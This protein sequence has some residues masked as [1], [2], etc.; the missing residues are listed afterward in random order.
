[1]AKKENVPIKYTSRDFASIRSDL[2][3]YAKKYYPKT[4]KDFNE[5]SFGALMLDTVAYTGDILSFYLD[6]QANESFLD[7]AVEVN[8]VIRL[9]KQT[10]YNFEHFSTSFGKVSLYVL[11]PANA[12]GIGVNSDYVPILK[13]GTSFSSQ[14]GGNFILTNDVD[15]SGQDTEVIAAKFDDNTSATTYYAIKSEGA[16]ISGDMTMDF[17][18][19]GDYQPY[20]SAELAGGNT[21]SEIVSVIDSLGN[22]YYEVDYL[23]QDTIYI[24]VSNTGA[25][26]D[27][28]PS[29]M[30]PLSVPRRFVVVKE[31]GKTFLQ[32][33]YGAEVELSSETESI[34]DPSEVVLKL[35]GKDHIVDETFDPANLLG[36]DKLGVSPANTTLQVVYRVNTSMNSNAATDSV[37]SVNGPRVEFPSALEG[38]QL[39]SST[40]N[41]VV[42]SLE[43]KNEEPILG[44]IT[45]P[46]IKEIKHRIKNTF[47]T[48]NRAVTLEDYQ[49]LVYRMPG[50]Y[51]AI[52]K[53]HIIPD[54]NSFKRNLNFYILSEDVS[55]K[56]IQSNTP[57]K[58]NLKTWINRYK[59]I[60]DTID[61]LDAQ[62][63]NIGIEFEIV[64][65]LSANKYDV[66][67][68]ATDALRRKYTNYSYN[69]GEPLYI[70]EIYSTLN[71]VRGVSDT[72]KVKIIKKVDSSYSQLGFNVDYYTSPD[73]RYVA[74]PENGVFEI[75][76]PDV[77]IKGA[78]K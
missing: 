69:I 42:G 49:S 30:K 32:F 52:K 36:T 29:I 73:G 27:V 54:V 6:Y 63:I 71:R 24:P 22:E 4:F 62:I 14:G 46:T 77:D 67:E 9:G 17:I 12:N 10:G 78:V 37:T 20:Y 57:L 40:M 28:V 5:A 25:D 66:L 45:Q 16:V 48:Q 43:V 3:S 13:R 15:F 11:V 8:N 51:G 23:S 38:V 33:G 7:T 31:F 72:L 50:K 64:S 2:V 18:E 70:T 34:K 61:I 44:D 39:N 53:C 19:V 60:N 55:G 76:F 68:A 26:K 41:E 74:M 58:R 21:I 1:M 75:K 59:M 56:L 65:M 35:H 47:A